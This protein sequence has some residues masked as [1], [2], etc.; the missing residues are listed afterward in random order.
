M[1]KERVKEDW[2]CQTA[3]H[4]KAIGMKVCS[5]GVAY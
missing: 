3:A 5:M 1:I 4:G 2:F